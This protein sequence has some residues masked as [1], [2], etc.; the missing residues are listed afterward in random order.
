MK[1]I[2]SYETKL[3]SKKDNIKWFNTKI[4]NIFAQKISSKF[5]FYDSNYNIALIK[6]I[7]EQNDEEKVIKILEKTIREMWLVYINDDPDNDFPGFNTLK[8]D[9]DKF[10]NLGETE[11]YINLYINTCINFEDILDNIKP[12]KRD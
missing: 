6:K 7:Y 9:I 11:D 8:C 3:I 1:K 2:S 12:R 4:K 10:R 5:R